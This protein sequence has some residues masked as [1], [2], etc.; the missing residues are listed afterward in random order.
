MDVTVGMTNVQREITLE[1][2]KNHD[3]IEKLVAD[4]IENQ[5]SLKL[6]DDRGRILFVPADRLAYVLIGSPEQRRVGFTL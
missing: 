2:D 3:Q 1:I 6:E 5:S 4:C